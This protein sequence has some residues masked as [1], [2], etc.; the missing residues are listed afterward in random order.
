MKSQCSREHILGDLYHPGSHLLPGGCFIVDVF[1]PS[2]GYM[3]SGRDIQ[4]GKYHFRLPDGTPVV[5]DEQ[6]RYDDARQVN[7]VIWS[8]T[9][10]G[11][12]KPPQKLDMRCFY[13]E[14]LS[15][16]LRYN[17]FRILSRYGDYEGSRF[18]SG[19]P[20]LICVCKAIGE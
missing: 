9:I 1:N 15:A 18:A 2:I 6:C 5:V 8:Y 14:E 3:V 10:G 4:R 20:K 12:R 7:R 17:G 19:S 16:L 11:R 13:P